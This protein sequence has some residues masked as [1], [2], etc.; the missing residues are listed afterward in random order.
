MTQGNL[1]KWL[2]KEGDKIQPG[3]LI[4]SIETDKATVDW[5]ATEAGYLAKILIPEGTKDITVGKPAVVTVEDEG[6]V[7]KFKDYS[8]GGGDAPAAAPKKEEAPAPKKEAAPAPEQPKKQKEAPVPA[9]PAQAAGGRVFASPL[10]RKVAQD[11]G[12]DVAVVPGTGP[13]SRVIRDDVL[14][15][16]AKGPAF[17][18][19]SAPTPAPGG[20]YTDIPNTQIRKVIAARLTE[21]KQT[22]PHYYLSVECR[23][24]KLLKVRQELNAKG[25]GSYKLSV[26]DF[27]IKAAALA[28]QKKPTCNSAWFGDFIRRYHNV[29]INVAVSTDEGLFTPIVQDADKK[30]LAT[31]ANTVKELATK[32]KERKLQ[33]HEF[34]G[35]TFTISNLGM[36]GVKQFAAVINPPQ[37]C[38]LAVGGTEKKVVPNEDKE[39]AAVQPYATAH[40]MTVTLSC[41]HRVVDGAMGAEWLKTFKDYVEDPVKMLL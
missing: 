33:P 18:A 37:S 41:D 2:K 6:D 23:V 11:Q 40:V 7:A 5:E 39:T 31:I 32:A 29:D 28:L 21:S 30:G 12:I 14:N 24:D 10:A 25:D 13:N 20:V 35:G 34:Q 17:A 4:A 9:A 36:F 1:A 19:A 38:I 8:P 26:N 16:A 15:Y 27:I 3:D 22:V